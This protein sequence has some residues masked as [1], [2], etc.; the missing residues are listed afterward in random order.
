MEKNELIKSLEEAKEKDL[1][2]SKEKNKETN[3][4][5]DDEIKNIKNKKEEYNKIES[6]YNRKEELQW[7]LKKLKEAKKRFEKSKKRI[8]LLIIFPVLLF[9]M[10][11]FLENFKLDFKRLLLLRIIFCTYFFSGLFLYFLKDDTF[12]MEEIKE[13][14]N[15]LDYL[16]SEN[17]TDEIKAEKQF[18]MYQNELQ[19]Y[20]S[21]NLSHSQKIFY[22]GI[23]SIILG[24]FIIGYTLWYLSFY[25]NLN[26]SV[27]L[28]V[29]G[30]IGGI[31][32]NFIGIIYLK[33]YSET[34]KV[35]TEFHTKLVYTQNLHFSNYLLAKIENRDLK[36]KVLQDA[37]L[38]IVKK[39]EK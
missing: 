4:N 23:L 35:L 10:T 5:R 12:I 30:G 33:M 27:Q 20:Y 28:V 18:K 26:N 13:V 11:F 6:Q 32:S 8:W 14:S 38:A 25:N 22:T 7:K 15:E 34:L 19:K 21:L 9:I 24:F 2:K 17:Q 29:T 36:E 3:E 37:I 39:I 16:D 31:L 1:E